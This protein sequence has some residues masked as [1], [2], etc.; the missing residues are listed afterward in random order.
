MA[1]LK[2]TPKNFEQALQFILSTGKGKLSLRIG[3]NTYLEYHTGKGTGLTEHIT[4]R[5]HVTN[6]VTFWPS[7]RVTLHT[8]GYRT[9]T[10]KE[11]INHFITGRV[12]QKDR[13]WFYT[14]ILLG[15][16]YE[17]VPFREGME[18]LA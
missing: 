17:T 16:E 6:I 12:S 3:N 9:V 8:G 11:R 2:A 15:E 5:L 1:K 10:T 18:V 13:R 14:S 4:V 7:G